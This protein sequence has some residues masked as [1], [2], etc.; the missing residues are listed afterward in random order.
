MR[1]NVSL[2]CVSGE[3]REQPQQQGQYKHIVDDP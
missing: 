2:C 1:L 3:E